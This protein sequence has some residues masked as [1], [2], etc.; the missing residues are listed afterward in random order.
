MTVRSTILI[1]ATTNKPFSDEFKKNPLWLKTEGYN[2][3][4][5]VPVIDHSEIGGDGIYII[6]HMMRTYLA[7]FSCYLICHNIQ[8]FIYL[9]THKKHNTKIKGI[10]LHYAA[11]NTLTKKQTEM[12]T[13]CHKQKNSA[14]MLP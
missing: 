6:H 11:T 1:I 3:E 4:R 14:K 13:R 10:G 7:F 5:F 9:Q 12:Y 8:T 2:G